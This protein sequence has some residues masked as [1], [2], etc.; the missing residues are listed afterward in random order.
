MIGEHWVDEDGD[1]RI[2]FGDSGYSMAH[3][4]VRH[5]ITAQVLPIRRLVS[6]VAVSPA[7]T[8]AWWW[9]QQRRIL[10][11]RS[12]SDVEAFFARSRGSER[13]ACACATMIWATDFTLVEDA[14]EAQ[15]QALL[16]AGLAQ[17]AAARHV[18][19]AQ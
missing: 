9:S 10:I 14:I 2:S 13:Y 4:R 1:T 19:M 17:V 7:S 11:A 15:K 12:T 6:V 8:N 5:L 18:A 16:F 3:S